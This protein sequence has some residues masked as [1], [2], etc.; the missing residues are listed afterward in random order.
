M[1]ICRMKISELKPDRKNARKHSRRNLDEIKRSLQEFGQHRA[2]V[3]QRKNKRVLIGNGMLAAMKELGW[4]DA[5]VY[6]VDDDDKKATLRALADNRTGELAEWDMPVLSDLMGDFNAGDIIGWNPDEIDNLIN[7]DE[8][9]S[10]TS[11]GGSAPVSVVS[12]DDGRAASAPSYDYS[13]D[14]EE[15]EAPREFKQYDENIETTCRCPKCGYE[16]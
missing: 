8:A 4:T 12:N 1:E 10:V 15:D 5:D 9:F 16:W 13:G 7:F 3:V 14:Y 11:S 2:L 6:L